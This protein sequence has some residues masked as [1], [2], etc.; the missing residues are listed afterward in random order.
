MTVKLITFDITG[1]LL[2]LRESVG[3]QY[4][5]VGSRHGIYAPPDE[6]SKHFYRVFKKL[7]VQHPNFGANDIGWQEWWRQLVFHTFRDS[8]PSHNLEKSSAINRVSA[9]LIEVYKTKEC[10]KMTEGSQTLLEKLR[11]KGLRLGVISN[12]DPRLED[13]LN[14]LNIHK[15]FNFVLTSYS[16]KCQKPDPAIFKI[17][18]QM[19]KD[20]K[21]KEILH[22]GDN[23]KLD[24][25]GAKEAGWNS[26]LIGENVTKI[27]V[28][29]PEIKSEWV[30]KNIGE[31][32]AT[33]ENN[34]LI[35]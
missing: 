28:D 18:E 21:K 17:V 27:T 11:S 33:L 13:I 9:D 20:L 12:Y 2:A 24:Y 1:T 3:F 32:Y 7:L 6:L 22:I 19:N 29:F 15:Y 23:P 34:G 14:N 4:A 30:V 8:L 10:W 25:L 35:L 31:I 26:L 16:A 5:K